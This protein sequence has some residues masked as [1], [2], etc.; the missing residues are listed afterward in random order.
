M[1][2]A[3]L[4]A[5]LGP[6]LVSLLLPPAGEATVRAY[7]KP[8][9]SDVV[10]DYHGTKVPDPYR[11]LEDVSAPATR[12]WIDAENRLTEEYLSASPERASIRKLLEG[13]SR[14]EK[15]STPV[16]EGGRYFYT[17]SVGPFGQPP[18]MVQEGPGGKARV[19]VEPTALSPGGNAVVSGWVPS[20]DGKRLAYGVATGSD[21]SEWRI[22]DVDTGKDL[23]DVL[24]AARGAMPAWTADGSGLVVVRPSEK[25][26]SLHLH[27]LGA[28]G[29]E[30]QVVLEAG[31]DPERFLAPVVSEDGRFLAISV[32]KGTDRRTG[33]YVKEIARLGSPLVRL[34]EPLDARTVFVGSDG[35]SLLLLRA[36]GAAPRGRLVTVDLARARLL[37]R[38]VATELVPQPAEGVFAEASVVAGK[39]LVRQTVNAS[40]RILVHSLK[41]KLERVAELPALGTV[42]GIAGHRSDRATF[43][44]F[45]SFLYPPTV[46]LYDPVADMAVPFLKSAPVL[47]PTAFETRQ[48]LFR[49]K[50]GARVPIFLVHRKGLKLDGQNPTLLHGYGGFGVSMTPAFSAR[51]V[52]F[53]KMGGVFA[54]ACVRGG[55]EYGRDWHDAG[56]LARK[57]STFDDFAAA[58]RWLIDAKVTSP[59]RLAI[60]G[61]SNGGLLVAAAL[62]QHPDLFGAAVPS[63]GV[64]DML[65]Y[66]RFTIGWAWASEYGSSADPEQ[67]RW[68]LAYSPLHNVKPGTVYPPVLVVTSDHDDRV[69]PGHSFKYA[70]AL[71]AAQAGQA[72]IL[73]RIETRAFPAEARTA[74]RQVAES[75]D[76]LA[77]LARAL[78]GLSGRAPV[79]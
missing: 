71:Q 33:L 66:Q 56:R 67:F 17:R 24:Q 20:R 8:P 76:V 30:D 69:V 4:A 42:S 37:G 54:Q 51:H 53:V 62:N 45:S 29:D 72:P 79:R 36:D 27:R 3:P 15:I 28:A 48:E 18:V 39:L 6:L 13:L 75:T 26:A 21:T 7:P 77:F 60:A 5:G 43:F 40:D 70:A 52:A 44:T 65:R 49:T 41:G 16:V 78:G 59:A 10:D 46:Y 50:D 63:V 32:A 58:A 9:L 64:M 25:G 68:L 19:V 31:D 11:A 14:H 57:Q 73:I 55:G 38:P 1:L 34:Y 61:G 23:S 22:R 47:D 12:A 35:D 2:L 74:E